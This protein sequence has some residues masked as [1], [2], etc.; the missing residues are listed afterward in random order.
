MQ[1][2]GLLEVQRLNLS[3]GRLEL[4]LN[5]G[6][7]EQAA[8][9]NTDAQVVIIGPEWQHA[10]DADG[11]RRLE[12]PEDYV[13]VEIEAALARDVP[14]IPVLVGGALMPER[15]DV[16]DTL[17]PLTRR[18]AIELTAGHWDYDIGRLVEAL[19]AIEREGVE[20]GGTVAGDQPTVGGGGE[21]VAPP[22]PPPLRPFDD[23][24][25][26]EEA[27]KAPGEDRGA[28]HDPGP[29]LFTKRRVVL[30]AA[31]LLGVIA[32]VTAYAAA[33]GG[34][35]S[36]SHSDAIISELLLP[37]VPD[38]IMN[39]CAPGPTVDPNEET[40]V[41]SVTCRGYAG[42]P[43]VYELMQN[44]LDV[45]TSPQCKSAQRG[46]S[47]W[48]RVGV[49]AHVEARAKK[50]AGRVLCH[51]TA[52]GR[53]EIAWTDVPTKIYARASAP[54]AERAGL[55]SWWL[56]KAG[57]SHAREAMDMRP[58]LGH[59]PDAIESELLLRHVP[60]TDTG[61]CHRAEVPNSNYFLRA[62]AC[63]QGATHEE[64]IYAYAHNGEALREWLRSLNVNGPG[65]DEHARGSCRRDDGA[66]GPWK[67]LG[68]TKGQTS[69]EG[70]TG[71]VLCFRQGENYR[72]VWTDNEKLIYASAT[73]PISEKQDLIHWWRT[74]AGPTE[75]G[76]MSAGGMS[77]GGTTTGMTTTGMTSDGSM[78]HG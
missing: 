22:A 25:A 61:G 63:P 19:A 10:V 48:V 64:V 71:R 56:H 43:V 33:S 66:I 4:M 67:G 16:P 11:D 62:I 27:P 14:V 34:S 49:V 36:S 12:N 78:G 75:T 1:A 20:T 23:G 44:H 54:I 5:F 46:A 70:A 76:H 50:F 7:T 24:G 32:A 65:L 55:Y 58:K 15:A 6:A 45:L 17:V 29:G 9:D 31:A 73:R 26:G 41:R 8:K 68:P 74:S 53:F 37:H 35:T 72:M 51:P 18:L 60:T 77:F 39:S 59:Y 42:Q 47:E 69:A 13:R 2:F 57:P 28:A 3:G 21:P 38:A 40:W 30:A 52:T